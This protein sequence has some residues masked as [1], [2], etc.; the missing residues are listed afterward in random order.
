MIPPSHEYSQ[1]KSYP[2]EDKNLQYVIE[3]KFNELLM[4]HIVEY[5]FDICITI[6]AFDI[7]WIIALAQ[8]SIKPQSIG[9]THLY[10]I[11]IH[12]YIELGTVK[13]TW[14]KSYISI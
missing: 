11:R 1:V 4:I 7:F 5:I 2:Y 10:R 13:W 3:F 14:E 8:L 12:A 9:T 6:V